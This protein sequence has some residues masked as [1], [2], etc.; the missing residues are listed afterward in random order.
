MGTPNVKAASVVWWPTDEMTWPIDEAT[1]AKLLQ[2]FWELSWNQDDNWRGIQGV[3]DYIKKHGASCIPEAAANIRDIS[4]KDLELQVTQKFKDIVTALK[5]TKLFDGRG[6]AQNVAPI[7]MEMVTEGDNGGVVGPDAEAGV[8]VAIA[9][10]VKE[11]PS[12]SMKQS[13]A[14]GVSCVH[15]FQLYVRLMW[16][17]EM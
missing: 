6:I 2:F 11:G 13:R 1:K 16:V 4:Q 8:A 5:S 10:V 3:C 17:S 15:D 7:I 9:V 12:A 14:K